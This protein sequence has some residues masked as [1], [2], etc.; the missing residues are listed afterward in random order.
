MQFKVFYLPVHGNQDLEEELNVFLRSHK[1][2]EID[3]Q[4]IANDKPAWCFCI[5][6][7]MQGLVST[8]SKSPKVNYEAVLSKEEF[9]N[10]ERFREIRKIVAKELNIPAYAVFTNHELSKLAKKDHI[11][12]DDLLQIPA[13]GQ[14]RME[15][16]GV[17]FLQKMN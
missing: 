13:F 6:Y 16:V 17:Y 8:T 15:K 14:G 4:F 10:Y 11:T 9:S 2:V 12:A 1:I 5:G 7:L 3:K